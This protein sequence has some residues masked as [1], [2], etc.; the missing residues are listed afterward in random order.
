MNSIRNEQ[1]P[2]TGDRK[3]VMNQPSSLFGEDGRPLTVAITPQ[4]M[5]KRVS[6]PNNDGI[7]G[8][9]VRLELLDTWGDAFYTGLTGLALL[10]ENGTIISNFQIT[11]SPQDMNVIEG[12]SGDYRTLDKLSNAIN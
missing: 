8:S 6:K 10:G 9:E 2:G 7:Q 3:H 12:H 11:A 4:N 1:R 5:P